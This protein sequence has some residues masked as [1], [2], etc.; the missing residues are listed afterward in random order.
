MYVCNFTDLYETVK[1]TLRGT[2]HKLALMFIIFGKLGIPNTSDDA[3]MWTLSW[4][5]LLIALLLECNRRTNQGRSIYRLE[6]WNVKTFATSATFLSGQ[7]RTKWMKIVF[8][9]HTS[10]WYVSIH[11]DNWNDLFLEREDTYFRIHHLLFPGI[12]AAWL[13]NK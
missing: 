7:V 11:D 10:I 9:V 2:C 5:L 13:K 1:V 12:R 3:L 4:K 6:T 8:D